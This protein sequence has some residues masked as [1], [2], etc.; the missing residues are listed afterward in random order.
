M[1]GPKSKEDALLEAMGDKSQLDLLYDLWT[2]AN[3]AP[4]RCA[5]ILIQFR[6]VARACKAA[7]NELHDVR[8][9]LAEV[10]RAVPEIKQ[11]TDAVEGWK[12][13]LG[14]IDEGQVL[15][16]IS[17]LCEAAERVRQLKRSGDLET[18]RQ[19]LVK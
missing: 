18:L 4:G 15:N 16:R 17:R 11:L 13:Q 10:E 7:I 1:S 19:L 8:K 5:E 14:S 9:Q 3:R 12:A 2:M 6:D